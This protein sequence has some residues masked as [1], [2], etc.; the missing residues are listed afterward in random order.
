MQ[1]HRRLCEMWFCV[2]VGIAKH[3]GGK[4]AI[5]VRGYSRRW[6]P[7]SG[8]VRPTSTRQRYQLER[9]HTTGYC[10]LGGDQELENENFGVAISD[11]GSKASHIWLKTYFDG[12][13]MMGNHSKAL[14]AMV[15]AMSSCVW[16]GVEHKTGSSKRGKLEG[17]FW[18]HFSLKLK[19]ENVRHAAG[20]TQSG[21]ERATDKKIECLE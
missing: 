2:L 8:R 7:S 3:G 17:K 1:T 12:G 10:T 20:V 13:E 15:K 9:T 16:L 14:L 18:P 6:G 4:L 19:S 11:L 5:G 21:S